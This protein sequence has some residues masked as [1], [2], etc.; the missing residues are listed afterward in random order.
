MKLSDCI[1]VMPTGYLK[2]DVEKASQTPEWQRQLDAVERIEEQSMEME[3]Q[4]LGKAP[5][6]LELPLGWKPSK[7]EG[8]G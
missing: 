6:Q 5:V 3:L 7:N 8:C 2:V 1:T 4:R